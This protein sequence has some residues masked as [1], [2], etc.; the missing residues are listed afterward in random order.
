MVFPTAA[1]AVSI[2]Q[3]SRDIAGCLCSGQGTAFTNG[4][5][6]YMSLRLQLLN[7]PDEAVKN[8]GKVCEDNHASDGKI[9]KCK[10]GVAFLRS[11]E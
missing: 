5:R 10:E 2:R 1:G 11:K 3:L 9:E 4:C 6:I 8:A 7:T